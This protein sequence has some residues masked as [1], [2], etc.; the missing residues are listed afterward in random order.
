MIAIR[1]EKREEAMAKKRINVGGGGHARG[2]EQIHPNVFD[3]SD[4]TAMTHEQRTHAK[5]RRRRP[6][7]LSSLNQEGN[8]FKQSEKGGREICFFF[9]VR[10]F[11]PRLPKGKRGPFERAR[12]SDEYYL[13]TTNLFFSFRNDIS[14]LARQFDDVLTMSLSLVNLLRSWSLCR[15]WWTA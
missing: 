1:K 10:A 7:F 14:F 15:K 11:C 9:Y 5:V 12:G 8:D 4:S 2:D 13:P 6:Q 3:T